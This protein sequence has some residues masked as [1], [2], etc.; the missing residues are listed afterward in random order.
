[1][2]LGS[3]GTVM[4]TP[5][6]IYIDPNG[7]VRLWDENDE[8][9]IMDP[10][11]YLTPIG[12]WVNVKLVFDNPTN[13]VDAYHTTDAGGTVLMTSDFQVKEV[14]GMQR[15]VMSP[16]GEYGDHIYI[17]DLYLVAGDYIYLTT[18]LNQDGYVN[19]L[20]LGAMADKWMF[21]NDPDTVC[22]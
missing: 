2:G 1:M 9:V 22:D 16:Q 17:D 8:Y 18:D 14:S 3:A 10:N 13:T 11:Y 4:D 12:E 20:D 7:W 5:T 6:Y 19:L 21:C 15:G